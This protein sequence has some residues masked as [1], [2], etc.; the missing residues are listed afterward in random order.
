[1]PAVNTALQAGCRAHDLL[2]VDVPRHVD[3]TTR[4]VLQRLDTLLVVVPAEVR[5][6]AAAGRVAARTSL[7]VDDLRV[8]V[9][10]PA[11]SS[12]RARA[13]SE[14]LGLPL[15]GELRPERRIATALD[16]GDPPGERRRG[17]LAEFCSRFLAGFLPG[18]GPAPLPAAP[19]AVAA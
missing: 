18:F 1:M 13:I 4:V 17:P 12:L 19:R 10:G 11:P 6:T 5:A 2:V 3:E 9:R 14:L 15:A 7:L 8:V 16:R